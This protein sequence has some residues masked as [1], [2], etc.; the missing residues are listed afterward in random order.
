MWRTGFMSRTVGRFVLFS[1]RSEVLVSEA[2]EG[3]AEIETFF[4]VVHKRFHFRDH[5]KLLKAYSSSTGI[6]QTLSSAGISSQ[7]KRDG[8]DLHR[9]LNVTTFRVFCCGPSTIEWSALRRLCRERGKSSCNAFQKTVVYL[10]PIA[11]GTRPC[12]GQSRSMM[13]K[14]CRERLLDH[15]LI[16]SRRCSRRSIDRQVSR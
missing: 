8:I 14:P 16:A 6:A 13:V 1:W 5:G 12:L 7:R 10:D 15:C 11:L 4:K 9:E 2:S 3:A